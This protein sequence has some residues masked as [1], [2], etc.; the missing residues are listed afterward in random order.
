MHP[1]GASA[2]HKW[3][4]E[5]LYTDNRI[6]VCLKPAGV[7]STDEPGGMPELLRR[8]LGEGT[9]GCVR[10]VHRLDR[11]VGGVM[12]YARSRMADSLL[13]RQVQTHEFKKEY[14]AVLEGVP[15]APSGVF[16]DLLARDAKEKKTFVTKS[17]GPDAREARLSYQL[18][19]VRDGRALVHIR[20]ETG[21]THQIR[22]Q[23][24][25]RALPL[26]GDRKYG[27]ASDGP[28]GLWSYRLA[29]V[30]PQTNERLVFTHTPP[31]S[32][33]WGAFSDIYTQI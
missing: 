33:P 8:A 26:C 27:A 20:L 12:V 14:L 15:D 17:P 11:P 19:A 18:L 16:V 25:A 32:A 1:T 22:A 9:A 6:V 28:I 29:F 21:R 10:V 5:L 24:S 23:F 13:S 3:Q 4:M 30:H 31:D 7:L 2:P